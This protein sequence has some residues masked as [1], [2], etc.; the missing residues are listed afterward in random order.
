[1]K[2]RT[3]RIDTVV[4]EI[5]GVL[6]FGV[7]WAFLIVCE[8]V[9]QHKTFDRGQEVCFSLLPLSILVLEVILSAIV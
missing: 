9:S 5:H 4:V 2:P 8:W 1:M 7:C 6:E 3:R